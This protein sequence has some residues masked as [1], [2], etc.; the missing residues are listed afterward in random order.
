MAQ[1]CSAALWSVLAHTGHGDQ[2]C[3][4]LVIGPKQT[5]ALDRKWPGRMA[6]K[7]FFE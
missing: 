3:G 6:Y 4:R 2:V 5:W 7:H 1:F